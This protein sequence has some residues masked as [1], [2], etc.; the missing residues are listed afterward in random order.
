MEFHTDTSDSKCEQHKLLSVR[1]NDF[2]PSETE[3]EERGEEARRER[4][5]GIAVSEEGRRGENGE[6]KEVAKDAEG[7]L[8]DADIESDL[9]DDVVA[10][11][12]GL[13][14]HHRSVGP[15][16]RLLPHSRCHFVDLN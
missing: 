5:A 6:R 14:Q 4:K 15:S 11:V 7:E 10:G 13:N 3:E 12:D 1:E 2:L 16:R 9:G 8:V